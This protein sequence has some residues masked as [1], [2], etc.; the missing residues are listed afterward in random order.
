METGFKN[1]FQITKYFPGLLFSVFILSSCSKDTPGNSKT[2]S[3]G[4]SMQVQPKRTF[5]TKPIIPNPDTCPPPYTIVIPVG[6]PTHIVVKPP[7]T[8][9]QTLTFHTGQRLK[10]VPPETKQ[11]DF[12]VTMKN[13]NTE[14][15]L[16][17]SSVSCSYCD[18]MGN[19]WFGSIGGG[20][21]KYDGK[22]FTNY[23]A[24]QG[25]VNNNVYCITEDTKGNIW[26]GTLGSGVSKY[27]GKIFT[28][29]TVA[30]GLANNYVFGIIE[31][32][33]GNIWFATDGGGV[34][35]LNS[36]PS[37]DG[38]KNSSQ[39]SSFSEGKKGDKPGRTSLF[40]NFTTA[41][42]LV[43]NNVWCIA[44]DKIGNL[45]FGTLG[46]GVSKYDG[47]KFTNYSDKDLY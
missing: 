40:T 4:N 37:P 30:Q 15:G 20:V 29:Y 36:N 34:S 33:A 9:P 3:P 10:I 27:D 28:T 8:P 43:N 7:A 45:W 41:Q 26:F 1:T 46:G 19:L 32:K 18:K 39:E 31:D 12:L 14:Q 5:V 17:L 13:Y 21:S 11:A 38:E 44:Q 23:N 6:P 22:S 47:K 25:L 2:I 16:A 42:G 24:S 35:R